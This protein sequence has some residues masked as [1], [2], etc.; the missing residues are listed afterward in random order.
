MYD[1]EW[2]SLLEEFCDHVTGT[3]SKI[4]TSIPG[5]GLANSEDKDLFLYYFLDRAIN[6]G[7]VVAHWS[8]MGFIMM[9]EL[10]LELQL[11]EYFT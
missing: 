1:K 10:L 4:K 3:A 11:K 5:S 8:K 7:R 9:R 2:L 6:I